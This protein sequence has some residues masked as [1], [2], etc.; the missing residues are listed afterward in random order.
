MLHAEWNLD[1]VL[2]FFSKP[3]VS[4]VPGPRVLDDP[5]IGVEKPGRSDAQILDLSRISFRQLGKDCLECLIYVFRLTSLHRMLALAKDL[6][7]KPRYR[8]DNVTPLDAR[9]RDKRA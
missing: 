8:R 3:D 2:Q 6:P 5:L 4:P 7:V 1:A 9:A